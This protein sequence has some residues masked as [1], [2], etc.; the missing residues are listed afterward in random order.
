MLTRSLRAPYSRY[1]AFHLSRAATLL[2]FAFALALVLR[3]LFIDSRGLWSDEAFRVIA[4]RQDTIFDTL[5]AAWAQPPS[6]PL[7]WVA[8]PIWINLLGHG[9][10]AVRLFSV[11]ASVATLYVTY[12]LGRMVSG[13]PVGLLSAILLAV[14][15]FAIETGQEATM[16][17][18]SALFATCTI[19]SAFS[20]LKTGR[21]FGLYI[22]FATLLLYTHYMGMLLIAELFV[23]GLFLLKSHVNTTQGTEK[24]APLPLSTWLRAHVVITLLYSPWLIAM[25][26]RLAER[27]DE[28]SHLQHRAGLADLYSSVATTG[29]GAGAATF[30]PLWQI[31]TALLAGSGLALLALFLPRP[32]S[33]HS[34]VRVLAAILALFVLI[35]VGISAVTG[36]WLVQPRFFTLVL[37]A[38][39]VVLAVG[40]PFDLLKR[41]VVPVALLAV[42][43]LA[44]WLVFQLSGV[45][46]FYIQPVHGHDGVRETAAWLNTSRQPGDL[47]V[48]NQPLLLWFVGQYH[49]GPLLGL[50]ESADVRNGYKLWPT[51]DLYDLAPSQWDV[52]TRQ[53]AGAN[54]IWLIYLPIMD[55]TGF[56]LQ[57]MQQHYSLSEQRHY[58]FADVYLFTK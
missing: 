11:P 41:R 9:D 51:P 20:M 1:S 30:W 54:R 23:A 5:R 58:P 46:T 49:D 50:P 36:A 19:W 39:L 32:S 40:F 47:V 52:L 7:Y 34:L 44:A 12:L 21:G 3:V 2:T 56:L 57:Q 28:L 15:P 18:W 45:R 43:L 16:Y 4:A 24:T 29:L 14:A 25:G 33:T 31:N 8:L 53:S 6:A 42:F 13:T 27:A 22:T 38:A 26:L 35:V 10:I 55:R 37:P 17:A 48:A